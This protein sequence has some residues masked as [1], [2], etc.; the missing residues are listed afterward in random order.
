MNRWP[1]IGVPD[2]RTDSRLRAD[3]AGSSLFAVAPHPVVEYDA[4]GAE[5]TVRRI[6]GAFEDVF[7]PGAVAGDPLASLSVLSADDTEQSPILAAV[8]EGEATSIRVGEETTGKA[9]SF[10]ARVVPVGDGGYVIFSDAHAVADIPNRLEMVDFL[11]HSIRNPLEVAKIH[12]EVARETGDMSHLAEV[13]R[14]HERMERISEETMEL[15]RQGEVIGETAPTDVAEVARNAW[16]TVRTEETTLR[17][18]SPG[19]VQADEGRLRELFENIFRNAVV[20]GPDGGVD[21]SELVVTVDATTDGFYVA[22]NGTGIPEDERDQITDMGFTT[23]EEGTGVGLA[24]V[25]D[26]A[27]SHGWDV[28]VTES[29]SGGAQ[30]EF[31]G[32]SR[33][34]EE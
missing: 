12:V 29:E 34:D 2:S 15:V 20:H 27:K 18:E 31:T 10:W 8:R 7:S 25:A 17:V 9:R 13:E 28:S 19:T 26:I 32:I 1:G 24:I 11:T 23:S 6:N 4:E 21:S 22:D 3:G 33:A 14:A 16:T 5:P 30:F